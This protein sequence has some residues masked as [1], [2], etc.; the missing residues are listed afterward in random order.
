MKN[1][2]VALLSAFGVLLLVILAAAIAGRLVLGGL[3]SG[4]YDDVRPRPSA[5]VGASDGAETVLDLEGFDRVDARGVWKITL[6]QGD[7]WNVELTYPDQVTDRLDVRVEGDR[8]VLGVENGRPHWWGGFGPSNGYEARIVMPELEGIDLSGAAKVDLIGFAGDTL[9]ITSSGASEVEATRS[10][11]DELELTV[12]G[13]G[14][15]DLSEMPVVDAHVV[16]SGAGN[17]KLNMNGG[18]LSGTVSGAGKVRYEGTV[19]RQSVV[20]SGFS[21]VEHAN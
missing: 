11:F 16:L 8:L 13:A 15:I 3:G 7:D 1:S 5:A 21:S 10:R 18:E 20:V 4:A 17:I 14:D 2:Q 12:S 19:S 9:A 6:E